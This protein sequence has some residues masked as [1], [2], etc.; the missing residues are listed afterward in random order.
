MTTYVDGVHY[1]LTHPWYFDELL[2]VVLG[3]NLV[4]WTILY[5]REGV[6]WARS[7]KD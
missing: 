2:A 1:F 5:V 6:R 7:R 4:L 3:V